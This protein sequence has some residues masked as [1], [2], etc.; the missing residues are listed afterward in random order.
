MGSSCDNS[1]RYS[2][3]FNLSIFQQLISLF[4]RWTTW[5]WETSRLHLWNRPH[6]KYWLSS[7]RAAS[8]WMLHNEPTRSA[9]HRVSEIRRSEKLF[10]WRPRG[11]LISMIVWRPSSPAAPQLYL[12]HT[13]L[14]SLLCLSVD[15]F[16]SCDKRDLAAAMLQ[17]NSNYLLLLCVKQSCET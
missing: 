6:A 17:K 8:H 4:I 11:L 15:R 9:H 7:K 12:E 1:K 10:D 5:K 14:T 13:R 16:I 3:G 2:F